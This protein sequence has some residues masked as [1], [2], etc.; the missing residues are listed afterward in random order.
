MKQA[1]EEEIYCW[2]A[3]DDGVVIAH[4]YVITVR[5]IPKP[6]KVNGLWGYVTAV[7]TVLEY[8][9]KGIGSALMEKAIAWSREQGLEHLIVWPSEPSVPFYERAGFSKETDVLELPL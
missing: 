4:I 6:G 8:R 5:K 7:Y 3:E 9:N 1:L 2:V